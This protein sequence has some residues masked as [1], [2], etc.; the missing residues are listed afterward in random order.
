VTIY[1]GTK[2]YNFETNAKPQKQLDPPPNVK[3][4]GLWRGDCTLGLAMAKITVG[5][6]V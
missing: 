5:T 6:K 1:K 2:G 3:A 4:V